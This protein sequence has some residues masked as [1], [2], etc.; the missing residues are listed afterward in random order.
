M[1]DQ[2]NKATEKL[3]LSVDVSDEQ[4]RRV[5]QWLQK[6]APQLFRDGRLD[7]ARLEAWLH[8]ETQE[9]ADERY[10]LSWSG[11][12]TALAEARRTTR[13]SLHPDFEASRHFDEA[14]HLLI[15]GENLDVL[16]LLLR[17]FH[18]AIKLIYIDPPYNTGNDFIYR[19]RFARG[20]SDEEQAA[21]YR[22][23][24]GALRH[25]DLY[26]KNAREGGRFHSTWLN[27][28]YPR[29]SL[30][31]A[32][33]ADDGAIFVSIDDNEQANLRLVL[34]ELYGEDNFVCDII[35]KKRGGPPNDKTI[36]SIHEHVLVYARDIERFRANLLPRDKQAEK[37]FKNPD[38]DPRGR[39]YPE[40]FTVNARGGRFT[41]SCWY[42]IKN[43]VS[44]EEQFPPEGRCW[45]CNEKDFHELLEQGRVVFSSTGMPQYKKYLDEVRDGFTVPSIWDDVGYTSHGSRDFKEL[46][47]RV[48]FDNPKPLGLL[49]RIVQIATD[50]NSFVLDFFAGSG[51]TLQAVLKQNVKDGGARRFIGVQLGEQVSQDSDASKQGYK[52][53]FDLTRARLLKW[54]EKHD[55]SEGVRVFRLAKSCFKQWRGDLSGEALEKQLQEHSDPLLAGS[56]P[57][58]VAWEL[59]LRMGYSPLSSWEKRSLEGHMVFVVQHDAWYFSDTF[60]QQ[61]LDSALKQSPKRV[62]ILDRLFKDDAEKTQAVLSLQQSDTEYTIV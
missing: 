17:P 29:L 13:L 27:M 21:G 61:A 2:K 43:P 7:G 26:R 28:I 44:G 31:R 39:W 57:Q 33:L 37:K 11:K 34:D 14:R 22:D 38:N 41:P 9:P 23:V 50:K 3:S 10:G 24:E 51:G 12:T 20:G 6:E 58:T 55:S 40:T 62:V 25:D 19:D 4:R 48:L 54:L 15:E 30:A 18:N 5:L 1:A 52:T 53:I 56:D 32:L 36:A 42:A 46:F 59:A 45:R 60:S 16:R 35:W 49:Q 8:A 47:G